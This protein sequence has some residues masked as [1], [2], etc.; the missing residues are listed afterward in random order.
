MTPPAEARAARL[1]VTDEAGDFGDALLEGLRAQ[2][3]RIPC[4]YFYDREGSRLFETICT[5]PEYYPTRVEL[6]LLRRHAHEFAELIGPEAEVVEFGAGSSEKIRPLFDCLDRPRAYIPVDISGPYLKSVAARLRLDYPQI[7]VMPIVADFSR[8]LEL[9]PRRGSRRVGFF[10]GSTIGNFEPDEARAFLAKTAQLLKGG[11][12]LVG[13]D[14][15]KDPAILHAAYNDASGVTAAFNRN[16]LVRA[17]RELGANFE[18]ARFFHYAPY[19][20]IHR[21]I[22]MY[23]VSACSQR[24]SLCGRTLSFAE[25]ETIHTEW[26]HK[27]TVEGFRALTAEAGFTPRAVWCDA[28]RLFSIHWLEAA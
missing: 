22:G 21:R 14:L 2:E 15:V 5:L 28:D 20:P 6:R 13:V 25:G 19:D 24:V 11:G 9:P 27:Y 7:A 4:K 1:A 18:P 12:L 10:P 23:L 16:L 26:S 17:N 8:G 3:K